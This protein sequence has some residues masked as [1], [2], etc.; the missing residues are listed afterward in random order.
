VD[1][2]RHLVLTWG[3][4]EAGAL[5]RAGSSRVEVDVDAIEDGAATL[6][7]L[8]HRDLPAASRGQP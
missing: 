3:W 6:L 8:R 2:P 5:V 7:R 1:P 4:E